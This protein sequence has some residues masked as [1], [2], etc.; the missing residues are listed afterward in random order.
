MAPAVRTR[1]WWRTIGHIGFNPDFVADVDAS[2]ADRPITTYFDDLMTFDTQRLK[3]GWL[4]GW[5]QCQLS[6]HFGH[7]S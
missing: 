3:A 7:W 5:C 1:H 4:E 2:I 6:T